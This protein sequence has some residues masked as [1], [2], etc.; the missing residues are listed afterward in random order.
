[1]LTAEGQHLIY[2]EAKVAPLKL[3]TPARLELQ[4]ACLGCRVTSFVC[5]EMRLKLPG[6]L[7]WNDSIHVLHGLHWHTSG[8]L[9]L[10]TAQWLAFQTTVVN[11]M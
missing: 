6:I 10:R 4:E 8:R 3:Q 7:A 9:G 2:S 11:T 5:D 1:M